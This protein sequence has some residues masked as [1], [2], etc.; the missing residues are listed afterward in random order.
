MDDTRERVIR[1]EE[2]VAYGQDLTGY[3]FEH[4]ERRIAA[5]E[6]RADPVTR[7][8]GPGGWAKILIAILLLLVTWWTTGDPVTAIRA[9]RTG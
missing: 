9:I 2:A 5:L 7:F 4:L 8:M 1:L 3:R 6:T